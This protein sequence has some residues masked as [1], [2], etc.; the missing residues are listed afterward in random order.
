MLSVVAA[1]ATVAGLLPMADA[2]ASTPSYV[3]DP[4]ALVN[5]LIGTSGA[6][7]TFPG[8]DMP[9]G[10]VQWSPDT[11]PDRPA[12]GGYEYDDSMLRGFSLAHISGPGCGAY[13]DV[14]FLPT[15]GALPTDPSAATDTFSH[16][17]ETAQAG[18]YA[19]TGGSGVR[20]ELSDTT[21]A[22]IANFN[23]PRTSQANL[24][25]KLAGGATTIDGTSVRVVGDREVTGTVTTGHFC[26]Q[27]RDMENDYTLHFDVKFN[28]PFTASSTWGGTTTP[29]AASSAATPSTKTFAGKAPHLQTPFRSPHPVAGGTTAPQAA[30]GTAVTNP[31]GLALT[32][33]ATQSQ[34]LTAKVGISFTSDANAALNLNT[35]IPGWNLAKV[36]QANHDAW[37]TYLKRIQVAGGSRAQQQQFYTALYHVLLHPNKFSDVNGQYM[38]FD[39]KVHTVPAGHAF[40]ANYSGWDIYRS[41]VQLASVVAPKETSDSIRSMLGQY[42]QMGQLPKWAMANGESYVMV[43][44]PADPIIADAYAFGAR[45]FDTRHALQAMVAEATT[46]NNVRPGLATLD[47]KGYL[48]YDATYGCCNF[49]GPVSTQLEYDSADYAVATYAKALGDTATYTKLASRAQNWQNV[50]NVGTGYMQAKLS[51]GQFLPGFSPGTS[52]GM[53]EGTAAQ[54]T[55]MVP[56]NLKALAAAKGGSEAYASYLD[57]LLSNLPNPGPTNADLSNEPSVEIPWEYSYVGKPWKTQQVVREAQQQLYF[58]AP[59]GQFGNDDLGA[60]SSWYVWSELGMYPETPGTPSL[61]FGSPVFQR[62]AV[63]LTGGKTLTINA[64]NAALDA[65]YVQ[66]LKVNGKNWQKAWIGFGDLAK[67]GKLDFDLSSSPNKTWAAGQD[68]APPSDGTGERSAFTSTSPGAGLIIAP[69]ASA[70]AS[71]NVTNITANPLT[72]TWTATASDGVSVSPTSG[73]LH[74]GGASTA[75]APVTVTAGQTE[76]RYAVTFQFAAGDTPLP[77]AS[78]A[79]AVAKPGELWPYFTNAGISPDGQAT[80]ANY[81][82]DGFDYSAN[83]LAAA[84]ITPGG[85]VK[86]NGVTYTMPATTPGELDNIEAD[87]QT[88]P[89]VLPAGATRI[90]LL[91]SATNS[92]RSGAV[93][94]LVVHY[95]DGSSQ[96]LP[97]GMSDWTLG[98]GSF[99][100]IAGN[101]I[102]ATTPYRNTTDGDRENV[103][104]YLF[105]ADGQLTAGKTVAS[106]TLPTPTGGD[107]HVFAVGAA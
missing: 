34:T 53:V 70:S 11:A 49:Y 101:T 30:T 48:P 12:G 68:A 32:F 56:F 62:T 36:H 7:D 87:G 64:P 105:T 16:A 93:G 92:G 81:D 79:V 86:S 83:A 31:A 59:V 28:Q 72:V 33:D 107:F 102:V 75:S 29:S 84:G 66:S 97:V 44:D 2:Q 90:G 10:M 88:V 9:F 55:P 94:T 17:T 65:P 27:S 73:T 21:H 99:P 3:T 46:P 41:Q 78:I 20:T 42:D 74:V 43:G 80:S 54:Y 1:A 96:N 25:L 39:N 13:G 58:D 26:G 71:V 98:A 82:G 37:N 77:A 76:G 23:F 45:D 106:V 51:S 61:V 63:H 35:E 22:G 19:V 104:T 69:G 40:Y 14:P 15:V 89:V 85:A 18:Y 50:F 24:L 4:A 91:G 5:P 8:P 103:T 52:A 38:G 100:P 95:T 47:E 60:M 67:G 57:S 6:V